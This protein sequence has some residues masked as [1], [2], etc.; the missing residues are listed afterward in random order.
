IGIS[1]KT[2]MNV[3]LVLD[4]VIEKIPSPTAITVPDISAKA[5]I[6]DSVYDSYRGVVVYVK[7][8]DG[9]FRIGDMVHLPYSEKSFALTEVGHL[10][11]CYHKDAVLSSGQIGYLCTGQKSV[12]DAKIGDTVIQLDGKIVGP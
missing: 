12:R 9:S 5:L 4:A 11:P 1:A 2:G 8:L 3:D 10:K 6:F 7:V